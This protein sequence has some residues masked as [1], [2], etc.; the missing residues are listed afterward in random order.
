LEE[1][2]LKIYLHIPFCKRKCNYCAF[3]SK[4]ADAQEVEDYLDAL[5]E[6]IFL[7]GSAEPVETI[8]FGGGTPSTLKITQLEKIFS[9]IQKN[10]R[11]EK[12]AE[13]TLEI[14]P[15]TVDE[16]YLRDLKGLG[17]NRLSVGV[18]SFNDRLLKLLG[19]IHDAKVALKTLQTAE[20][21]FANISLDLMY[22]LP[23]Q[24]LKDLQEDLK[25]ISELNIQHISIYGLEVE[26][27]TKFFALKEKNL[28]TLPCEKVCEE[29]YNLITKKIPALGFLRYEISN[30]AKKNYASR[31]NSG[32]WTLQKYLGFGAGAHSFDEKSRTS[33]IADV[34]AYTKKV[35]TGEKFSE[36]EEV[37]TQDRLIEEFCFLVLRMTEGISAENFQKK[38]GKSIFSVYGEV[39]EKYIKLGL[40]AVQ[41]DRIFL[42][43]RGLKVSNVIFAD[44]LL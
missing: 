12:T 18:Q 17:F 35:R 3:N 43:E 10:F 20:K 42:T 31:H 33:N 11:V 2:F 13:V 16:N 39:L 34:A 41:G 5:T 8:Y 19:R 6:E 15:G 26:E 24:S 29:M 28:L 40:L 9:A 32:Y 23:E 22:G 4:I 1:N 30:F 38:F 44:F 21:F 14:N 36:V 37:L 27:G 25:I 7:K